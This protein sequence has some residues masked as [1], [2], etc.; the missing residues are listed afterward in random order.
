MNASPSFEEFAK[1][2]VP[3]LRVD[4]R[5]LEAWRL[6]KDDEVDVR[7]IAE[8]LVRIRTTIADQG[9]LL[10]S[11]AMSAATVELK[12]RV[13]NGQ[14]AEQIA[15]LTSFILALTRAMLGDDPG[16]E[17]YGGPLAAQMAVGV[18]KKG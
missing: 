14:T 8:R 13:E 6:G 5:R 9:W 18:K 15:I 2:Q 17:P 1:L 12:E 10:R 16:P 11:Q 4:A 7:A 3:A